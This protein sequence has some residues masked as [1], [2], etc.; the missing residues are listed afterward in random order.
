MLLH[1]VAAYFG[2]DHNVDPSGKSVVINKTTNTRIPDQK[3][4]EHIKDDRSDEFQK[5]YILK[6]DNSSFDRE[7]SMIRMRL[8][9]DKRSKSMEEREEEYQRA[10]E[11]IFAH[12]VRGC[13]CRRE[14]V[15]EDACMSTKERRQMFRASRSGASRQSSSETE[16]LPRHGDPRPWSSTDSSDSSNQLALRPAITKASSFSSIS[17]CLVRGDST[18]SSKSTGRLSKT[19]SESCSSVGSSS[20]SLSRPQLALPVSGSSWSNISSAH[21]IHP[22]ADTRGSAPPEMIKSVPSQPPSA[23]DTT[24]YFVLPLDASGIPPGSIL[25]SPHTGKPFIHPDG[26]SVVYGPATVAPAAAR[27]LQ[28]GK[29]PQQPIP[30]LT[31]QQPSHHFH[32]QVSRLDGRSLNHCLLKQT[33]TVILYVQLID[34]TY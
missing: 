19:G 33:S 5:R 30:A 20:S 28:P 15:D 27:N 9:A 11:R 32:S 10:R 7:D 1:R 26:S 4:S 18:A 17:P 2:M 21:L 13:F 23:A 8:K 16:T 6:R 22:A 29:N 25:V 34:H 3:F 12:D 24:N 14:L 31:Q